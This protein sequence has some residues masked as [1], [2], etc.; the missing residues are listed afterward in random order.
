MNHL[1]RQ[2]TGYIGA[3]ALALAVDFLLLSLLVSVL[4]LPYLI[5]AAMSFLAGT[6]VVYWLS[7]RHVFDYR[8]LADWRHEFAV[9]AGLGMAGLAVNLTA[10]YLLVDGL[11]LHYLVAKIG[12]AGFTFV[13]NFLLRRWMLFSPRR[14]SSERPG[15]TGTEP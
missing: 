12:A 15:S 13:A 9:F 6:V 8:R 3:S 7:I 4:Q 5:A 1:A 14:L 11:G 10:M 2:A